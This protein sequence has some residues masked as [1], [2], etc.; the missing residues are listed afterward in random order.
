MNRSSYPDS[1]GFSTSSHPGWSSTITP[2]AVPRPPQPPRSGSTRSP[3]RR[4]LTDEAHVWLARIPPRYQPLA[5]AR[6]H[7]HIVNRLAALW[8]VPGE[9][10][11]YFQELM[12]S[13]RAGRQGF[14]F[15]VLTELADLQGW[16]E[17]QGPVAH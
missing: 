14:T 4:S 11:G 7:P 3:Q 6:R 13:R 15:E 9:L 10:P 8:A 16:F 12:L 5:T 2:G 1:D 17:Q